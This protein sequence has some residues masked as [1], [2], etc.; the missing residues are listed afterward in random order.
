VAVLRPVSRGRPGVAESGPGDRQASEAWRAWALCAGAGALALA[1]FWLVRD[2]LIDDAYITLSYARNVATDLH[3][4]LIPT[5]P[6]NSATSPLNVLLLGGATA[7]LRLT[8]GVHPIWGLGVVFVGSA[9]AM[10]WWWNQIAGALRL[11]LLVPGLGVA[12]VLLNPFVL[13][14][15]G[16]EVLLI[17]TVLTGLLA[18]AIR[19]RPVAFGVLA[20]LAL[21][22]RID[23][24]V[25]VLPMALASTGVRRGL[26]RAGGA[27]AAVSLPWFLW[28]WWYFGSAIPDTFVIK[29]LQR[30]FGKWTFLNG[31]Q[32]YWERDAL[33]TAVTIVP[34]LLG[35]GAVLAWTVGWLGR[36]TAG[37]PEVL[38]AVALGA[39]GAGYYGVYVLL[40]VPPY[41]WYYVPSFAALAISLCVLLGRAA[42][43]GT[44]LRGAVAL[45]GIALVACLVGL[46]VVADVRDGVPWRV[47]VIF[48]NWATP[49]DYARVGRQLGERV[50]SDTVIAPPEIGTLAYY[51]ECSIVDAFADRGRVVPLIEER[52]AAAGP[53][54]GPVLK[55]NYLL[56]DH[57]QQPRPARYR[58][59]WEPGPAT[60][61]EQWQTW[62]P[63]AG[64]A[65]LRLV[66]LPAGQ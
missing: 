9:V 5:E 27:A 23:L 49:A 7:L 14:A 39:A 3:W 26:V 33:A 18:M 8:G 1:A 46:N 2:A 20:G 15:V 34:A 66:E 21:L 60:Q 19:G 42:R 31:L 12:L 10:A 63:A 25:F 56:L 40:G 58:L 32:L 37:C 54:L 28:S 30:S 65:H 13:S 52:I 53:V 36:A 22:T 55:L 24:V 62:S 51:C 35:L 59:I 64:I 61:P 11:P 45:P 44:A 29:T 48:G 6:A 41:Q 17:P 43:G 38:P 47:P 4:G 50:G 16:L 57:D